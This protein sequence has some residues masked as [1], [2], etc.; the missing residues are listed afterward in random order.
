MATAPTVAV[1]LAGGAGSRFTGTGHKLAAPLPD[2]STL[3]GRAVAA[4]HTAAIGPVAVVSGAHVPA[5]ADLPPGPP[6]WPTRPGPR[7][8]PARSPSPSGGRGTRAPARWWWAW[9]TSPA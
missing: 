6:S 3:L 1:V 5:A 4:A 2:G 7:A 8:R 9:A